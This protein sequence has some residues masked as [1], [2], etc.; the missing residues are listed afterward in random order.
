MIR[1]T[2]KDSGSPLLVNPDWITLVAPDQHGPGSVVYVK[3]A[4]LPK[5]VDESFEAVARL[6]SLSRSGVVYAYECDG[7][8][9]AAE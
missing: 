4:R 8:A 2:K 3:D 7:I 5:H 6:I 9:K 1:L